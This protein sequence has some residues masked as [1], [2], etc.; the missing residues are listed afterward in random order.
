MSNVTTEC[1]TDIGAALQRSVDT[2]GIAETLHFVSAICWDHES[3]EKD[4]QIRKFWEHMG[5]QVGGFS[6][7]VRSY[8]HR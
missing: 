8:E 2:F 5:R 6:A 7:R 4:P 1:N 3:R